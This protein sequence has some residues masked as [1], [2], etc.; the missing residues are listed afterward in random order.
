MVNQLCIGSV[1]FGLNYGIT[2][3]NGKVKEKEV[4][5]ILNLANKSK[6][7][8]IDTAKSY[9]DSEEVIGR[10]LSKNN[11]IKIITKFQIESNINSNK[12]LYEFLEDSLFDTL[13]KLNVNSLDALLFHNHNDLRT[14]K[15]E[16]IFKWLDSLKERKLINRVGVSIYS[17]E[18]LKG[19]NLERIQLI[20]IPFSIYDQRFLKGGIINQLHKA[21]ISVHLRSI[22]LQ[23]LILEEPHLWPNTVSS[24]F[25]SHHEC[26]FE[27][28][29]FSNLDLLEEVMRVPFFCKGVEAVVIGISSYNEFKQILSI[30]EKFKKEKQ[31]EINQYDNFAWNNIN[32]IDPRKWK[33]NK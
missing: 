28:I 2:N 15:S 18:D 4:K 9:N 31:K 32:D 11:K 16:E 20:Q 12:N 5:D 30:W 26:F 17:P 10:N 27:K 14:I 19:L 1:Q 33:C 24:D 13:K 21:G 29:R 25:K 6:V 3:F 7:N 22:F 8:F 23:G